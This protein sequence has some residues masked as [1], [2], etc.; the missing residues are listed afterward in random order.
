MDVRGDIFINIPKFLEEIN[1]QLGA[2]NLQISSVSSNQSHLLLA[3]IQQ[4]NQELYAQ[5]TA[6]PPSQS[7]HPVAQSWNQASYITPQP[8]STPSLPQQQQLEPS[9]QPLSQSIP[10]SL[11][12]IQRGRGRGRR[13]VQARRP[14]YKSCY[15]GDKG[16]STY[17]S[18]NTSNTRCPIRLQLSAFTEEHLP[19]E[20][21]ESELMDYS[22]TPQVP[23]NNSDHTSPDLYFAG[24]Q[25]IQPVVVQILSVADSNSQPLHIELDSAATVSYITL[26]EA[27]KHHFCINPITK[28][29]TWVMAS[30]L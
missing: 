26:A 7:P 29:P 23:Q 30:L 1:S 5:Q 12:A 20:V 27:T 19:P 8:P 11:V 22:F 14:F 2:I 6:R 3:S 10:A 15:D 17:L 4:P 13:F 18:H 25:S 21:L 16:K 24:L 28:Y 9:H